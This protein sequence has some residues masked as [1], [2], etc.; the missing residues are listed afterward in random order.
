MRNIFKTIALLQIMIF[1]GSCNTDDDLSYTCNSGN[2]AEDPDGAFATLAECETACSEGNILFTCASGNC[3]E[4]A[5]GNFATLAE[6]ES[7][8]SEGE[9]VSNPGGGVTG[10]K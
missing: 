4:D 9:I 10:A 6:C 1:I 2:C 3:I 8:C 7:A 5:D